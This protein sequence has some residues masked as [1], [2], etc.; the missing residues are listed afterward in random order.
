MS[1]GHVDL[2]FAQNGLKNNS[3]NELFKEGITGD[4]RRAKKVK[5]LVTNGVVI[6]DALKF[7]QQKKRRTKSGILIVHN[8]RSRSPLPFLV[9]LES[10]ESNT[11]HVQIS[12]VAVKHLYSRIAP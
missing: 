3:I 5:S 9:I 7:V 8:T 1:P 11:F 6:T 12:N 10:L 2:S 4:R